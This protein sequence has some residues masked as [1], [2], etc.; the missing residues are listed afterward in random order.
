MKLDTILNTQAELRDAKHVPGLGFKCAQCGAVKPVQTEGG[1]GYGYNERSEPVCYACCGANDMAAMR[2][3]GRAT[4][5]L[6]SEPN[7]GHAT[8]GMINRNARNHYVSNWPGTLKI[9]CNH[10][11]KGSH[12]IARTRTDVW[13]TF[14]GQAW[15]GVQLGEWNQICRCRKLKA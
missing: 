1:T 9:K 10:A 13:F 14:D 6:T 11:R 8:C 3:T 7:E 12:N 4:M 2:A 15:H 5:Y